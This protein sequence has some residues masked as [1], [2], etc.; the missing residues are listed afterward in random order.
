[1][2][3]TVPALLWLKASYLGKTA[4]RADGPPAES[5]RDRRLGAQR[6]PSLLQRR[7]VLMCCALEEQRRRA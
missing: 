3:A 2:E 4:L 5:G 6:G 7:I 1:M